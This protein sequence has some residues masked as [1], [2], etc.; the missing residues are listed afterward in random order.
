MSHYPRRSSYTP[1]SYLPFSSSLYSS[2]YLSV[3]SYKSRQRSSS[4]SN[5]YTPTPSLYQNVTSRSSS[6]S[7]LSGKVKLPSLSTSAS[8]STIDCKRSDYN[9]R[10]SYRSRRSRDYSQLYEDAKKEFDTLTIECSEKNNEWMREKQSLEE[11]INQMKVQASV[12]SSLE[13]ENNKLKDENK[14][15]LRVLSKLN[16]D[17]T[18]TVH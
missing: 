12:L 10:Y 2:S 6:N 1:G 15:L 13:D 17:H 5:I 8:S 18:Q 16:K 11:K 14:T 4:Y 3:P 9:N 7:Q